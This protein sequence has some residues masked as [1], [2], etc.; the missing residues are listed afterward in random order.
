MQ[1]KEFIQTLKTM[2]FSLLVKEGKLILKGDKTKLNTEELEAIRSN[3]DIIDYIKSHKGEL[4]DYISSLSEVSAA[5]N[6]GY[7]K[8]KSIVDLFRDQVAMNPASTAL[9]FENQ[10]LSYAELNERASRLANYLQQQGVKTGTLVPICIERSLDMMVGILGILMAGGAYVP[11]DT[12]YPQDRISFMLEDTEA[13]L[14]LS[15]SRNRKKLHGTNITVVELD[16]DWKRISKYSSAEL[17]LKAS[18]DDLAYVIYTSGSTGRPKGVMIEHRSVVSLVKGAG[19]VTPGKED[20]VLV[21]GSPSFDATTF[22]Y[23][24]MLLNGG[25]L[26]LCGLEELLIS[27]RLKANIGKYG[28]TMM[29]FTS[30]WFNQLADNNPEVFEG[31]KTILVGG[32]KLSEHHIEKI[33]DQYP[34]LQ[35]ING[36]GPTENTTFSLTYAINDSR[37][38]IPIGRPLNNRK[39]YILTASGGLSPVGGTGEI[40]LGGAGL[41]RGYLNNAALTTEKFI[42]DPFSNEPGARL[43]KT[44]DLGRWLP[45]GNIEY[46]GRID[47]QV[48]IRGY[49]IELGEIESILNQSKL[50]SQAVVLAKEDNNGNKRLVGYVV[51]SGRFD[52]QELLD[53]LGSKLPDYMIPALWVELDQLPLTANGKV[54]KKALPD[55][56]LSDMAAEYVAPRN[57]TEQIL[58]DIWQDLLDVEQVGINDNFFE[59]GGDS[60]LAIRLVSAARKAF[61]S[62]LPIN[63]VFDYP[64]LGALAGRLVEEPSTD[65]LPPIL[66]EEPRPAYIPLSFSQERL[67]FIDRLEGS[68][69]YHIPSVLRLKGSLNREALQRTLAA[70]INRHEVLRTVVLEREGQG[71]QHVMPV[72]SWSLGFVEGLTG[73]DAGLTSL[74][75]DLIRKPF[76]LSADHMLRAD[77]I[78]LAKDD[79]VL[80]VTMH[81]IASDGWS[82]SILVKEVIAL[83][84][85]YSANKETDLPALSVQYADYAI[86]QRKYL[87]GETLENKLSYWKAKLE[88]VA[89]LQLPT[90]FSRPAIQS[91]RGAT[92]NFKV[93]QKLSAQLVDLSHQYGATLYMT[94]LAAFKVLLYRYSG[95]EDICVGTPVAGRN[96]HELEGLIGFF[97]N[98][99]AL[100][101]HVSGEM[102][103]TKLLQEVKNTTLEAY[104]HQEVPFEKVVDAV[105]KERDMSRNPLFQVLFVLQ[106]TPEVPELKLG[107]LSLSAE[108]QERTTT[109]FDIAFT[110]SE[111]GSGLQGTVE[112]GTDLYRD[113]TIAQ[114]ISHYITLLGSIVASPQERTG[115]LV[116][117]SSAEKEKLLTEFNDTAAV[118]PKDKS[119]VD[120]FLEQALRYP[121]E[122][123]IVYENQELT[124]GE[125]NARSNQ[126]AHYLQ[127]RGLKPEMLVPICIERSLEMMIAILGIMKAGGAYVPIDPDYPADRIS[128]MLEDIGAELVL[129]STK[130]RE[131]LFGCSALV[132]EL[133][134]DREMIYR[135]SVSGIAVKISPN[136]LGYLI[137]TSGS[138]G[139]PKGVMI[140]HGGIVN[141]GISQSHALRLKPGMR[142][143]QFASFGFDA[144]CYEIFNT[145]LS[146]GCLVLCN[147]EDLLSVERFKDLVEKHKIEVAVVPPSFQ[148][149]IDNDTLRILRTIVSAGEPL[150]ETTGKYIQS[151]GI[152]LINAYG[153]TETTVCAT[154][155]DDPIRPDNIITIGKPI[156]N[157]QIYVLNGD[158]ELSPI[159]VPGEIC[160]GGAGLARG[161][162][163]RPELT[164]EKFIKDPFSKNTGARLYRTGDQGRWLSDGNIEYMGRIDEQVKIRGFRIELGEIESVLNESE[165]VHQ[166]VILAKGDSSGNKRLVAYVVAAGMYDKKVLQD[167]LGSK[168]PDYMV[169]AIWVELQ[170]IPLTPSGKIDRKALPDPELADMTVEY[171]APRTDTELALVGIWKELLGLERIGAYDNFFELGGHSLLAMRVVSSIRKELN[172]ELNIRDLFVYPMIADLGTY[173]DEQTKGSSLPAIVAEVRPEYIPLSFSQERLWFIDRLE[174][175]VQYH[176][177]SVLRLKG[178]L[179]PELLEYTLRTII[180]RHEVLRTVI[181]ENKG[182]GYQHI[183]PAANWSLGVVEE[184]T[185]KAGEAALTGYITGLISKLFDLSRDY[186]L[187]ADL[188]ELDQDDHILVVTMHH[189]ASDGWSVSILVKEVIELYQSYIGKVEADLPELEV[190]YADYAIWQRKYLRGEVLEN[191]LNYWK[192]KLE[193]VASLQLPTD[194]S[195]PAIQSSRGDSRS[196][197]I[198]KELSAQLTGLSHKHGVT[199]YMILLSA[200]KVLLYRYSGQ[201]DICVGTPVAGRDHHELESLIGFF[202]NTLA[203]RSRVS[204]DMSFTTLLREVKDTTLEAYA[205]QEVPF[206]KVVDAV[207]KTRDMSR[208]PL[209][210]VMFSLQNTPEIPA[211][212]LGELSLTAESREHTT[213]QYD[214]VFMLSETSSGIHATVEYRT[215]LY[216]GETI[217]RMISHYLNLLVSIVDSADGQ[218]GRLNILSG[219][220]EETLLTRFNDTQADYPKDKNV[221]DLFEEQ[222]LRNPDAIALI[223]ENEKLSYGELN[224][225]SNQLARYLVEKG[226]KSETLVPICIER[227]PEMIIGILGIL[228]AGGAYVPIDPDYPADRISYMLEDT[229]AS[230]VLSSKGS[231]NR[232]GDT[233]A[234]VIEID[235]DW[236]LIEKGKDTNLDAVIRSVQ[237]AYVIYTSGSTGRPK[238][239]MIEHQ[240]LIN[241]LSNSEARYVN[242]GEANSGSFIHLSYTFDA[243]L[244]GLFMPLL[245][246]K[247]LVIGSNESLDVFA[248]KN[249]E[250]YAPYDFIKI[251]PSHIGLLPTTFKSTSGSWLTGKLVIGGE[252]LR[253]SQ[254]DPFIKAGIGVEIINEYGPT[255]ATVG[256]STYSFH[257]LGE[258][259]FAQNEV[260]IGKPISNTLIHILSG[261]GELSPIGVPGEVC[262]GGAGLA[263][264]YLNRAELTVE[265]FIK[266]PSSDDPGARLY[267]TG[268]LGRWLPDGNIEYMGRIDDQVKIRGFRI[269]LGEV[270]SILNES[271]LVNQAV[272]L[273]KEDNSG[274]KRLVAYVVVAGLFDKQA[275]QAYLASK[276]PY[277]MVPQ[278][279]VELER[280]PLTPNGKIDRKALPDPELQSVITEYVAPR[281]ATEQALAGIWQE[282][283]GLERIGV[284]D[285]FFELGGHSLLAMRAVSYI[286]R[287]LLISIPIHMLFRFTSINDLGKYLELEI[288]TN[289]N[290]EEKNTDIFKVIDV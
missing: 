4:I 175:S 289:G 224:V 156:S 203:L 196:F 269:E 46:L 263:R 11:L 18:P 123:A 157:T 148:L 33:R 17:S 42:V 32:E 56:E 211:L 103:F 8:D 120:L 184:V 151:Q 71:Y 207:V 167:Y 108:S 215:D 272:V 250:K 45:D 229:A 192:A 91:S 83:Y 36:Y 239:V 173:L 257:T 67:W 88:G 222:V 236:E 161:Y 220:E 65:I 116:M 10:E 51:A 199:M 223:Y 110:I 163:N 271:E 1:V 77:L 99:L 39:A 145:F 137:Y 94:L 247:Y 287:D 178:E 84:E 288:Q 124:Y 105:V 90:D 121:D 49:R 190:Q 232:L 277:Y 166:S 165:L 111:T 130:C 243:S 81:H 221:I 100:R 143:L 226:V 255:E 155:S 214:L 171:V 44:G 265:K 41:A 76:D 204:G 78:A 13:G 285:N 195:R 129:S 141:L 24:S 237:L 21:T 14:V 31:L 138:T 38:P 186:M 6:A 183:M 35:L 82:R 144:S 146:G 115:R 139:K 43:Y 26:I 158:K 118:Y 194:Y 128:Y 168:L 268:D 7:P 234:S 9:I 109:L 258:H 209:F 262:I 135:E 242:D 50:V 193:G 249:L 113:E 52:K 79:H 267:K 244:T 235:G 62:E 238:G 16:Q 131:K 283:L 102:S 147:K 290:P 205:H 279:W 245:A 140:E 191:K 61:G 19:Y 27:E 92:H 201:E 28:V 74:I 266:D 169:P 202:I 96:H 63:D 259:K 286:Q 248:D 60:L 117:L 29:W 133:D 95:Q 270:E 174:G 107:E 85:A 127:R 126:L 97:I 276:L 55:P 282:L 241:Y 160:V 150:N 5:K 119:V 153:P 213:T 233:S 66:L 198:D 179:K 112:Y 136:Q 132:I 219:A 170:N 53:Y 73:D 284:Y 54:D 72:N 252:A 37:N 101:S 231:S 114:M 228:K 200:F 89:P 189:I 188:I 212:K 34:E 240:S 125:L 217:E 48:K 104:T 3:T 172:V 246:G 75:S 47:D 251:T 164:S 180:Q 15:S 187:R 256:C 177:P 230:I 274:N 281:N 152:R 59:L 86:W 227:S 162:F 134:T 69:Q 261:D 264:G 64:T 149:T 2:N 218:I 68:V 280:L 278:L 185:Y 254:F 58:A 20:T 142:T 30:S 206:E 210:Q 40:Y 260:P 93:D 182:D 253:L 181:R 80:V 23:W 208:N 273:A 98:T 176:I 70:I 225:R 25:R 197:K 154:L 275:V 57:Q 12:E 22:E 122:I 106:N 87:Q 216:K 159:G